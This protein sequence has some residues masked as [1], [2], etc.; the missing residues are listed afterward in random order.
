M[1]LKS[2]AWCN[3]KKIPPNMFSNLIKNEDKTHRSFLPGLF[4]QS[5]K[6][7]VPIS[8]K[9]VFWGNKCFI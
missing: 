6:P 5:I 1:I 9:H 7:G 3:G 2:S 8:M 4:A